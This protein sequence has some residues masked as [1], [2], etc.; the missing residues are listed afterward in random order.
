MIEE[1]SNDVEEDLI[2]K[3]RGIIHNVSFQANK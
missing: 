1:I 3:L 2:K